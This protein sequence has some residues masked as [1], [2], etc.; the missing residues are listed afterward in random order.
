VFE[1]PKPPKY[2]ME[3]AELEKDANRINFLAK[4][5]SMNPDGK[6]RYHYQAEIEI[7][8]KLPERP[9]LDV[10]DLSDSNSI[11]CA[12]LYQSKVLFHGPRFQGVK[13]LLN[14]SPEGLTTE[15][16]INPYS[17]EQMG[18]FPGN[19]FDPILADVHLQ[20]LLIWVH[21]QKGTTGLPLQIGSGTQYH[22]AIPGETT[23]ATMRV[24]KITSHKLVADVISHDKD[25]YIYAE[26]V[27]AEITLNERL[28]E[29]FQYNQLE[30]NQLWP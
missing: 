2:V 3:L 19:S 24:K 12:E 26:V 30:V 13:R 10:F 21:F 8:K 5:S 23:Y 14:L 15:C 25:G 17:N 11:T 6:Q 4:I 20:S 18:Q 28:S 29:L 16:R 1:D 9:R 7:R 22:K 27:D